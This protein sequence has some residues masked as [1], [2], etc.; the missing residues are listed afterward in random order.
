MAQPIDFYFDF[1]SPYGYVAAQRVDA[2]AAAKGRA[3]AWHPILLGPIFKTSGGRP[4]TEVGPAKS[5]YALRDFARSARR[6][7]LP[8]VMPEPF[9]FLAVAASRAYYGLAAADE[10]AARRLALALFRAAFGEGRDISKPAGVLAVAEAAGIDTA[11]VAKHLE[12]PAVKE[13]LR[14][15]TAAAEAAG[16]FGSPFFLVDGEPFWGNDRLDEVADWIATG[17]W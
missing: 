12:D 9:P 10:P 6:A 13:R 17:G 4:L 2:V 1:S 3:V 11:A 14:A 8:F 16:V 15:E 7:G 5:A